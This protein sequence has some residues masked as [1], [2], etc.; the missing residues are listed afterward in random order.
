MVQIRQALKQEVGHTLITGV[1][2]ELRAT[3]MSL[4]PEKSLWMG[5]IDP[6]IS[7]FFIQL[8]WGLEKQTRHQ[9]H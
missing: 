8:L 7:I 4:L 1:L 5:N 6:E 2:K 9:H 3:L